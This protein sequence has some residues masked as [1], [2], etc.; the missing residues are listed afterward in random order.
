MTQTTTTLTAKQL[1]RIPYELTRHQDSGYRTTIDHDG[2]DEDV[3]DCADCA[4]ELQAIKA[5]LPAGWSAAWTGNGN[6]TESDV[7]I[8]P[9]AVQCECGQVTGVACAWTGPI[10]ETVIIEH[11]PEYLRASHAAAGNSGVWPHNG[12]LRLRVE[13]SCAEMLAESEED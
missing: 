12:A 13:R 4:S 6:G 7:A 5:A 8:E 10:S 9:C 11:M 2:H 3:D 1:A